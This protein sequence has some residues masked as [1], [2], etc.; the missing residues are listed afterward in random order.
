MEISFLLIS[1]SSLFTLINPIGI[2]PIILTATENLTVKEYNRTIAK[3]ILIAGIILLLFALIG[4]YILKL[5]IQLR[6]PR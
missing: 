1:I 4:Q 2:A 6:L 3:G 5:G